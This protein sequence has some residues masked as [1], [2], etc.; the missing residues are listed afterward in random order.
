MMTQWLGSSKRLAEY[1][2]GGLV[3]IDNT[4]IIHQQRRTHCQ[5]RYVAPL[6]CAQEA[7]SC[8]GVNNGSDYAHRKLQNDQNENRSQQQLVSLGI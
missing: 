7:V 6:V 8:L 3:G 4:S 2:Q 5:D 1:R